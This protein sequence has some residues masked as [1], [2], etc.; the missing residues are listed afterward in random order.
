MQKVCATK[1]HGESRMKLDQGTKSGE[2]TPQTAH[3][4]FDARPGNQTRQSTYS[5]FSNAMSISSLNLS[6]PRK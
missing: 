5:L 6:D 3:E 4:S 2:A 1:D